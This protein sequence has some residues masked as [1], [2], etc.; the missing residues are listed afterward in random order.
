MAG[1]LTV[2]KFASET[3]ADTAVTTLEDLRRHE[4]ITVQDAA[5]VSWPAGARKPKTRQ[6]H[7]LA[8][9]GA[10]GGAFW[11]LL[12]GILFFIPLIGAAVG[13]GLGAMS[14]SLTD[15]GIDDSLLE[16]LKA[17]LTPGTSALFVLSSEATL[18][19]VHDEFRGQSAQLISTN[20]SHEQ[21][22]KL[23]EVFSD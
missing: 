10:L 12:F 15:V 16:E 17:E 13:A 20:L 23:R 2:W 22:A 14:G 11:G 9:V 18:D 5:V 8:G 19:R 21:E 7:S 1:T 3:G 6:L 4:L